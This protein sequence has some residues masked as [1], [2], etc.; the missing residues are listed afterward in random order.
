MNLLIHD[1]NQEEWNAI[2]S[3]YEGWDIIA[4]DGTIKPCVGCFGCWVKE[5]GM[6]V[7]K[8]GYENIGQRMAKADEVYVISRYTYGGF[9]S[10]IK[11]VLD[12][13]ISFVL[14][15]FEVYK[16][17]MH[18][19][20]RYP[21]EKPVTFIFRGAN[22]SEEDKDRARKYVEAVC[23]NLHGKVKCVDFWQENPSAKEPVVSCSEIESGRMVL[24][25][26]SLRGDRAN[27]KKFVDYL[28]T[29]LTGQVESINLATYITKLQDLVEHLD[30]AE[31]IVFAIPL[32]VDGIPSGPLRLLE[33]LEKTGG[34]KKIYVVSNMGLYESK[35]LCNLLSMVKEWCSESVYTYCGGIAIGAG[36][37]VAPMLPLGIQGKG[38]SRNAAEALDKFAEAVN[39][40]TAVEDSYID[41][42][43]FPRMMYMSIANASW[44]KNI[45]ANG[46]KK[47]D[48]LRRLD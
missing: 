28:A 8:D 47:K 25:N 41:P 46:L 33:A 1:L 10:F 17:E 23:R 2:A 3:S 44:P 30:S 32:Y 16:R 22:F 20:R 19:K 40:G 5:P 4:D 18:H 9:S 37:M 12:R 36:E 6:C 43:K 27:S 29:K 7:I 24:L 38:P 21:G 45:K 48:L 31:T 26:C 14:P 35:Q 15:Y 42:Y 34:N 39:E 11:N 13:A